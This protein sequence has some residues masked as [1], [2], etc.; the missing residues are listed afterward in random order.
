MELM[1][2]YF[3]YH[4]LNLCEFKR[5]SKDIPGIFLTFIQSWHFYRFFSFS[6]PFCSP[7][8]GTSFVHL[9]HSAGQPAALSSSMIVDNQHHGTRFTCQFVEHLHVIMSL[10]ASV[11]ISEIKPWRAFSPFSLLSSAACIY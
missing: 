8:W 1:K 9:S 2:K 4:F 5:Q 7:V 11:N 3:L 6:R 10:R